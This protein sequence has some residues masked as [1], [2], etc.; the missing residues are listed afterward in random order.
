MNGQ[1]FISYRRDDSSAWAGRLGD[2]LSNQ[3][4]SNQIFM[5][6]DSVELGEDFVNTIEKTVGSCDVLIAVIGNGWLISRDGKRR[7]ENSEDYVRIEIATALER[8]IRLIPVLVDGASMP[9]PGDLP[10]DLKALAR[11]NALQLSHDRFRTDSDRLASAVGRALEKTAAERREREEKE[12]LEVEQRQKEAQ[13]QLEAECRA[14]EEK[15]RFAAQRRQDEKER[16]EKER[17]EQEALNELANLRSRLLAAPNTREIKRI[18]H[19]VCALLR[20]YQGNDNAKA[21]VEANTLLDQVNDALGRK[22]SDALGR[23]VSGALALVSDLSDALGRAWTSS[24]A[25]ALRPRRRK[26]SGA[27][28]QASDALEKTHAPMWGK[29]AGVVT[30]LALVVMA[31]IYFGSLRPAPKQAP[32][33]TTTPP[34]LSD[35]QIRSNNEKVFERLGI[36]PT[37]AQ[38][39]PSG[40]PATTRMSDEEI[41]ANNEKV[42]ERLG[43]SPTPPS[44]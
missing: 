35:D 9:Q 1:I 29:A 8:D 34:S 25:A 7:L 2:R 20:R 15:E 32:P 22:V 14:R 11:R 44:P 26:I 21:C 39:Q 18:Y 12:R 6:V 13:D 27:L 16:E 28:A 3:F 4:P 36:S 41:R 24:L 31:A 23:K 43:I 5:D 30:S 10:D 33:T 42:F 40:S 17:Q 19:E 38:V 37:P